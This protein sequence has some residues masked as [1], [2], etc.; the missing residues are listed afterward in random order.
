MAS[1]EPKVEKLGAKTQSGVRAVSGV[2]VRANE[3]VSMTK[4]SC[5]GLPSED[6][7][8]NESVPLGHPARGGLPQGALEQSDPTS[9][10][11]SGP[12]PQ[13][14]VDRTGDPC[15]SRQ[16]RC[17]L[18]LTCVCAHVGVSLKTLS[19]ACR[20]T[21]LSGD[22]SRADPPVTRPHSFWQEKGGR[23]R[24]ARFPSKS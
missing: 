4:V 22:C 3:H 18:G 8:Q 5:Q 1:E 13:M 12:L 14:L 19:P 7:M 21:P 16:I 23:Q 15:V 9:S 20:T 24:G 10:Y 2:T 6:L 11:T 17:I